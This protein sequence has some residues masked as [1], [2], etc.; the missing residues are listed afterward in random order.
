M[1]EFSFWRNPAILITA[2]KVLLISPFIPALF[3]FVITFVDGFGAAFGIASKIFGYG[4]LLMA[5]LLA[6]AVAY[7]LLGLI[8]GGKY[9]VLFKM[10]DKGVNHIQLDKRRLK[11]LGS[12][13]KECKGFG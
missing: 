9:F 10:D 8:Y 2:A 11:L 4:I 6:V 7:L 12:L 5:G 3:T 1:D 13:S